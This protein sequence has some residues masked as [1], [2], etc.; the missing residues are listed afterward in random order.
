MVDSSWTSR[1]LAIDVPAA[2]AQSMCARGARR[3]GATATFARRDA[4]AARLVVWAPGAGGGAQ[5][6]GTFGIQWRARGAGQATLT[7]LSWPPTRQEADVWR[8]I[9]ELAGEPIDR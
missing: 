9:E 1:A 4:L 7:D 3:G 8:A 2:T 6:I 5:P